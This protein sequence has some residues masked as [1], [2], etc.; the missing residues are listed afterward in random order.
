[1]KLL[2]LVFL[3]T[4]QGTVSSYRFDTSKP[5]SEVVKFDEFSIA[6]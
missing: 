4:I 3:D 1:M 6:N 2:C 5:N